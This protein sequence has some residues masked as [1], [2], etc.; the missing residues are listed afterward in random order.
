MTV[1]VD[2]ETLPLDELG[3]YTFGD[4]LTHIK[5]QNRLVTHVLIDGRPPD[6]EN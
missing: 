2:S 6:L 1:T 3:L 5:E 4:V